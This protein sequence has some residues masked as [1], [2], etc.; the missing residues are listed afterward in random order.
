MALVVCHNIIDHITHF[1]AMQMK[2]TYIYIYIYIFFLC[3][4]IGIIIKMHLHIANISSY[5]INIVDNKMHVHI[6]I[7]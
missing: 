6:A 2:S 1:T 5:I 4:Y 3:I 7:Q